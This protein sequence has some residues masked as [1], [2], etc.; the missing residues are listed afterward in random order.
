MARRAGRNGSLYINLTSGG[1]AEPVA[2]LNSYTISFNSDRYD[3]TS[4][5]DTNK[6]YVAGLPD[7]T[8]DF[9]G[10][11]DDASAQ[12]FTAALDGVARK[13]YLYPDR[14]NTASQ[15]FFGSAFFDFNVDGSVDGPVT[16]NGSWSAASAFAKI[17]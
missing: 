5:G 12:T 13:F 14:A 17:G 15:Y 6:A 8:G 9:A 11:Y 1:T 2:Y 10:F 4:F 3:V 16:I 7:A